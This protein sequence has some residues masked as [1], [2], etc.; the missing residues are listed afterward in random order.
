VSHWSRDPYPTAPVEPG[1]GPADEYLRRIAEAVERIADVIAGPLP[2]APAD[3]TP[4][5]PIVAMTD[6]WHPEATVVG[7][8]IAQ[9]RGQFYSAICTYCPASKDLAADPADPSTCLEYEGSSLDLYDFRVALGR[10]VAHHERQD[11]PATALPIW[12]WSD[13]ACPR[14]AAPA[15]EPCRT[16]SGRT[17]PAVHSGRWQNHSDEYW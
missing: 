4:E 12:T 14:F 8:Y 1:T 11:D 2:P 3:S 7:P 15:G 5:F 13:R 16:S 10:H 9:S 6:R 17:S